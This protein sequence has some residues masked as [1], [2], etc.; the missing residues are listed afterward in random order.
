MR[1]AAIIRRMRQGYFRVCEKKLND[2]E[3]YD[4]LLERAVK[5]LMM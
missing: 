4:I 3:K 2:I 1:N 5:E